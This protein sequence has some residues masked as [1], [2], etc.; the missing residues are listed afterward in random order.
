MNAL[1]LVLVGIGGALG[2]LCRHKVSTFLNPKCQG[3]FPWPTLAINLTSCTIAGIA[4]AAA[5]ALGS[6]AFTVLTMGFLGGFSTLSTMNFEAVDRIAEGEAG[7]GSVY[8]IATYGGTLGAAAIGF[9]VAS[10]LIGNGI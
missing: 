6:L 4:L 10:S 3:P 1:T 7:V 9:T 2:A 8:L 5:S